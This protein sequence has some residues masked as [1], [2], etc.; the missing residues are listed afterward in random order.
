MIKLES[1]N[2]KKIIDINHLIRDYEKPELEKHLKFYSKHDIKPTMC[3]ILTTDDAGSKSYMKGIKNF[4]QKHNIDFRDYYVYEK[5]KLEEL[6]YNLNNDSDIDGIMIMYPTSFDVKDTFFMNLIDEDKDL[7]GLTNYH[8]GYLVQHK[9]FIKMNEMRKLI[10]PPT[11]KGILYI[12]KHF[13]NKYE[14]YKDKTG[15]YPDSLNYN[16]FKIERKKITIINDSLAV[17][18]SLGLML[19]NENGSVRICH[20]YTDFS[21]ILKSVR[22][23]D[24]VISAVPS[25]N[26]LIPTTE[27]PSNSIVIDLSFVGNFDYPS[28]YEKVYKIAPKWN[29]VEKG[30]RINDMTLYRL[31]SNLFYLINLKL[32][33]ALLAKLSK[34]SY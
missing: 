2:R 24:I 14:N 15:S 17:G 11:P 34:Y 23:S 9:K 16:P 31:I 8:L 30:N 27:I 3:A 19:L 28:I 5:K 18:R 29:L 26:F 32:S 20:E 4:C 25:K 6:I 33:D 21:D 7:E 22:I 13:S 12:F 1:K 10:I